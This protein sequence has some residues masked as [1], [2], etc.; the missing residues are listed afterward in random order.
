MAFESF[1]S[2]STSRS[3]MADAYAMKS[4]RTLN[5]PLRLLVRGECEPRPV[6]RLSVTHEASVHGSQGEGLAGDD[7][8]APV[9]LDRVDDGVLG[10]AEVEHAHGHARR[11]QHAGGHVAPLEVARLLDRRPP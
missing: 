2:S 6:P 8:A 1:A 9:V 5:A 11:R 3:L 7:D 10:R 4:E